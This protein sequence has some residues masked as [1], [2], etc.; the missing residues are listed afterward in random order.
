MR[1]VAA[2]IE[3]VPW[4]HSIE[5]PDGT[6]TPGHFDL[7]EARK[8]LPLPRLDGRRCLDVGSANGYWAFE[9]ERQGAAEVVSLDMEDPRREDR[10]PSADDPSAWPVGLSRQ[11]FEIAKRHLASSVERVDGSV[12]D[13]E[14]GWLGE[15]DFV[16]I[17]SLLLHLRDPIGALE[18]VH[19][20]CKGELLSLEVVSAA[21]SLALPGIPVAG[22]WGLRLQQW[23][24]PNRAG[25][26]A[27]IQAAGFEVDRYG[28]LRQSIGAGFP[29]A[30]LRE[31][32][33]LGYLRFVF[34]NKRGGVR[35]Q[36]VL[37]RPS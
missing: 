5:L 24:L 32:R 25:H 14:P 34:V 1:T 13:L 37:A 18:A 9:M 6:V 19:R 20:V 7:R 36:W 21:L 27:L 31:A 30:P 15:F 3:S 11:G 10:P 16:F 33:S 28:R 4:Y 8:G 12:Y 35:S 17:G 22:M 23:W 26:R 29:D 2:D